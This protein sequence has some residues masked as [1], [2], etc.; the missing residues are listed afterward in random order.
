[1]GLT[2]NIYNAFIKSMS[3]DMGDEEFSQQQKDNVRQLSEDLK[4]AFVDFLVNQTFTIKKMKAILEVESIKTTT[5]LK[6]NVE[7]TV[8]VGSGISVTTPSG[9]GATT[10]VGYIDKN[11]GRNGVT[12]PKLD[13]GGTQGGLLDSLGHAYIGDDAPNAEK[14]N[15]FGD[16][17]VGIDRDD[18]VEE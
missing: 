10:S 3:E 7:N 8:G 1:M 16:N 18:I 4:E 13:L 5:D 9:P 12:I 14:N 6:A 2:D 11:L 17:E 15:A